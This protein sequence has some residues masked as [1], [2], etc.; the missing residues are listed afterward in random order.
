M[1][2]DFKA[3]KERLAAAK[4]TPALQAANGKTPATKPQAPAAKQPAGPPRVKG[5]V[6]RP[7]FTGFKEA[8]PSGDY[9]NLKPGTYWLKINGVKEEETRQGGYQIK[10]ELSVVHVIDDVG[11]TGHREGEETSDLFCMHGKGKDMFLP[12]LKAFMACAL[13]APAPEIDQ[14]DIDAMLS[15]DQPFNGFVLEYTGRAATSR[16]GNDITRKTYK[17][18]IEPAELLGTLSE[19]TLGRFWSPAELEAL[20]GSAEPFRTGTDDLPS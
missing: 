19:E 13:A 18:K 7:S 10:A 5:E 8:R 20:A 15:D 11:G 17:R 12:N 16:A 9:N 1:A 6:R 4:G 3:L 14:S 2:T